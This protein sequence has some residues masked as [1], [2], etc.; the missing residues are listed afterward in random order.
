LVTVES[1]LKALKF[2]MDDNTGTYQA[3]AR[4]TAIVRNVKGAAIWT[5]RKDVS[6]HGPAQKLNERREGSMFFM[7]GVTVVG[8]GPFTLEA[9][10]EDLLG[11]TTGVIQTP[12]RVGRNAP[13]L[14]ATDAV[15]VR[16]LKASADK[17]EA[18]QVLS[19]D[20]EALSPVLDPV[21]RSDRPVDLQIYLRLYPDIHSD[22]LKLSME[23]LSEGRVAARVALPF[24]SGLADSTREGGMSG[25]SNIVGGQAKEFPYLVNLK[26]AK[27]PAG[28]YQAIIS[29]R[30][31]DRV[32]RRMVPFKVT[33]NTATAP[34]E[35]ANGPRVS[36]AA[37]DAEATAVVLPDIEPATIDSSG[38]KMRVEDQKQH[39]DAAAKNAMGYLDQLPNFRCIQE[40]HRF[41]APVKTPDQLKEADSYKDELI[42]EDG[43]ERYQ[44]LES[45][46][47][48]ADHAPIEN[49]GIRSR[50]EFGSL[51]RGLFDPKVGASYHWAGRS[52]ALGVLCQVFEF[53]VSKAK[54]NFVLHYGNDVQPVAYHGRAFIDDE[55]GM[56][57]R[58]TIEGT[59]LP[60]EFGLQSP[61]LSLDYGMVKIGEDDYLLPLLSILQLRRAKVFVRNES[62]FRGYRRFQAESHI[63][64]D[65]EK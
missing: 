38:L 10:V 14:V 48:K 55:T 17:F 50:N 37:D 46:G 21:Y 24:K 63:K 25:S 15:V 58:L 42:L 45:A 47:V 5:G 61:S 35:T 19:Y 65:K 23:V 11:H 41:T 40:T 49:S 13:G 12:L 26:G 2:D 22:P 20:G 52:M 62:V 43:K 53:E 8:Q 56:V 59:G 30:Q 36:V 44:R 29:I 57:R 7:R 28:D 6:V 9:K 39:W 1:P 60:K 33:G 32:I 3:R 18:D 64:Y 31:G 54:S 27:F 16:P 34:V 51:L 4:V